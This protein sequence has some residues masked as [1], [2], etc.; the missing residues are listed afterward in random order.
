MLFTKWY[1]ADAVVSGAIG[2]FIL[3][4]TWL[5]LTECINILMEGTP[6]YV[7]VAALR[8]AMLK[9]TGVIEVHDVHV[10]TITSGLDAMSAHVIIDRDSPADTVLAEITRIGQEEFGLHHT[11]IQVEQ[12]E[13]KRQGSDICA[14]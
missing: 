3:P 6:G 10:W 8:A 4:R 13:C 5:L 12:V 9:V 2:L 1:M 14:S 11:T 7:D